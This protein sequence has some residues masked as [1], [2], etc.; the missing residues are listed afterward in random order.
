MGC[1]REPLN[2]RTIVDIRYYY[3]HDCTDWEVLKYCAYQS[4]Q[5]SV[6]HS[7]AFFDTV[8][9]LLSKEYSERNELAV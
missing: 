9:G 2:D 6:E 7:T 4:F 8:F 5:L 1:V 3:A